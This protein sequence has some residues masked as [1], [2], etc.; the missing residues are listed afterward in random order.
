MFYKI[1]RLGPTDSYPWESTEK[2]EVSADG[3][4]WIKVK[5]TDGFPKELIDEAFGY[6]LHRGEYKEW[7]KEIKK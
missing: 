2:T 5:N 3:K 1:G 4:T 7:V 6:K